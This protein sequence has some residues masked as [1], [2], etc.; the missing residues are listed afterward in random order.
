MPQVFFATKSQK[1]GLRERQ[2]ADTRRE[3]VR[4]AVTDENDPLA[5]F[6]SDSMTRTLQLAQ[7]CPQSSPSG[8]R[9]VTCFC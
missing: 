1:L 9:A 4:K 8:K 3:T 6:L 5:G 7:P 2:I